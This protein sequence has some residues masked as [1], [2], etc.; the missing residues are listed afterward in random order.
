MPKKIQLRN[1]PDD[2]HS[3]LSARAAALGMSLSRYL[4]AELRELAERPP[5]AELRERLHRRKLLSAALNTARLIRK[6]RDS[7]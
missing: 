6:E 1:V 2:L 3:L 4:L 5:W 7:R